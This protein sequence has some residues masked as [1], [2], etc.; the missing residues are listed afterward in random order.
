MLIKHSGHTPMRNKN[1][2]H[3]MRYCTVGLT[4]SEHASKLTRDTQNRGK[5]SK[6]YAMPKTQ[7]SASQ[8]QC[9]ADTHTHSPGPITTAPQVQRPAL[10]VPSRVVTPPPL[11]LKR[12][13]QDALMQQLRMIQDFRLPPSKL[14]ELRRGIL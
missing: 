3:A 8:H 1:H 2:A 10:L 7:R 9:K 14:L 13:L 6:H 12:G 5:A 4:K 11:P